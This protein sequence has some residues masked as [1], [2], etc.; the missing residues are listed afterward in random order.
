MHGAL[1]DAEILADVYLAMTGGQT[2][3]QLGGAEPDKSQTRRSR[4]SKSKDR[5]PLVVI[6]ADA[7]EL[8]AHDARLNEIEKESD[9]K[10]VW[11]ANAK[12]H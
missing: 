3:L 7:E 5:P 1:L 10:C 8:A 12:L 4:T 11:L 6:E 2:D 9:G